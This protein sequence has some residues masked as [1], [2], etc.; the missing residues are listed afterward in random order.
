MGVK[1]QQGRAYQLSLFEGEEGA[2]RHGVPGEGGTGTGAYEEQQR[3][4][5][6]ERKRALPGYPVESVEET[7][8]YDEYVRWCGRRGR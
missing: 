6:S 2:V 4:T 3:P 7:A 5:A 1:R 8:G